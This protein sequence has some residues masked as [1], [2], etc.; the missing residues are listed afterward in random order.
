MI[1]AVCICR[2]YEDIAVCSKYYLNF[3]RMFIVTV[4]NHR[5]A[6]KFDK[7]C[8][9]CNFLTHPAYSNVLRIAV[10]CPV[11]CPVQQ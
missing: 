1:S 3:E 8:L 10:L 7:D 6:D 4:S 5:S 11:L 9:Q 2:V